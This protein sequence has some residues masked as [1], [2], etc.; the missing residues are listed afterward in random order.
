MLEV[1]F[2]TMYPEDKELGSVVWDG[3]SFTVNG[4][5]ETHFRGILTDAVKDPSWPTPRFVNSKDDPI[6]FMNGLQYAYSGH[7]FFAGP[8]KETEATEAKPVEM[9][10]RKNLRERAKEFL[11]NASS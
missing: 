3:K 8:P 10:A 7:L 2:Y 4:D 5:E 9:S 6:A 1:K 11:R